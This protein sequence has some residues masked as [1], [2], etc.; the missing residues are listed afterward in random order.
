MGIDKVSFEIDLAEGD[1]VKVI[2]G[3]FDNFMGYVEEVNY[4]K[5]TARVRISMFGRETPVELEFTQVEKML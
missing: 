1:T 4:M 2:D 3:P 5:Q